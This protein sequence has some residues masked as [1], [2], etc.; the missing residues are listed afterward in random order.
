MTY[1]LSDPAPRHAPHGGPALILTHQP[2]SWNAASAHCL[3]S[4][5]RGFSAA[6]QEEAALLSCGPSSKKKK[7]GYG[8]IDKDTKCRLMLE[9][10]TG[11][12]SERR[13]RGKPQQQSQGTQWIPRRRRFR[14]GSSGRG[15]NRPGS[16]HSSL[17]PERTGGPFT[18]S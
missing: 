11:Q 7:S 10:S 3:W 13:K 18:L 5:S 6:H 4:T 14:K 1:T 8:W 9:Q 2:G 16:L 17:S 15:R 12:H